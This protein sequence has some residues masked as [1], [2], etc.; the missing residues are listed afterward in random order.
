MST[1][2][3]IMGSDSDWPTM[4]AA[5][6]ALA[7]FE[8]P[9]EVGV[10]SAHRTPA[11]MIEYGRTAAERGLKVIIAGAGGA[12]HL[13]GM[14]ASVTPLPVIGVPVPLKYLDGMDSLLSIVQMPAGVPVATVSIGNARNAGLLAVRILGASD[15]VLRERM[16]AYQ[17]SLE[18]LVAEKEANLHASLG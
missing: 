11:K 5:A 15:P 8:V 14:V 6:E 16:A 4:Q 9:Y 17:A 10:V 18:E 7:E 3:L 1:V 2:G 12:A 13:P